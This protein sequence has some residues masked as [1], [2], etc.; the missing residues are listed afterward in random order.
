[1]FA[2]AGIVVIVCIH[3]IGLR[4]ERESSIAKRCFRWGN[5]PSLCH[6]LQERFSGGWR[7]HMFRGFSPLSL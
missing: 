6:K 7:E 4:D 3:I 5:L 2:F 1:V